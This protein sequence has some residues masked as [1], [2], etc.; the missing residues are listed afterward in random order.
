MYASCSNQ[1]DAK[2]RALDNV[3]RSYCLLGEFQMAAN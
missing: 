1:A 2:S 3:G